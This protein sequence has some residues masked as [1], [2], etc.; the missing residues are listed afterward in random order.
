MPTGQPIALKCPKCRR[1]KHGYSPRDRGVQAIVGVA[2]HREWRGMR[3][4]RVFRLVT[5]IRCLDCS[6]EWWSTL[7]AERRERRK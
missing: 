2:Q 4:G 7:P 1:G 6:H 3:H 5:R